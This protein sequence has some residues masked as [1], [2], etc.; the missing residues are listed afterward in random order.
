MLTL[1]EDLPNELIMEI[2]GYTKICDLSC[3]FWNLN[4]RFNQLIR[5]LRYLSL[6]LTKNQTYENMLLYEQ[7]TRIVI[8]TLE[9]INLYSFI[10]LRSLILNLATENHLKQIQSNILPNLVYL[11]LPLSFDKKSTIQLASEVF[12]NRF[13]SLRFADLGIIDMPSNLTWSQSPSLRSIR[14]F[15]P[16]I[17]IIPLILQS[18]TQLI[19]FQVRITDENPLDVSSLPVILNHPLKKLIF[20]QSQ[21]STYVYD[22]TNIIYLIPNIKCIDLRLCTRSFIDLIKLISIYLID[23]KNFD[24]HIIEFPNKDENIDINIIRNIHPCYSGI[25]C[26]LREDCFCLY[27][28]KKN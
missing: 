23:L 28:S 12:S 17:N 22:I 10:N 6:I 16:N 4:Q 15:S 26:T 8:V 13:T 1:L 20:L 19:H 7:I 5:S 21:N 25:Q 11:A 9:N 27:T 3:G 2:F 14:I 18:C 24:C